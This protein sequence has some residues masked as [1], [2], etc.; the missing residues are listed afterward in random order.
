[1]SASTSHSAFVA[2]STKWD[3][4]KIIGLLYPNFM[5]IPKTPWSLKGFFF[6]TYLWGPKK[7]NLKFFFQELRWRYFSLTFFDS[8][9]KKNLETINLSSVWFGVRCNIGWVTSVYVKCMQ[10]FPLWFC[11]L[12]RLWTILL[13]FV[14]NILIGNDVFEHPFPVCEQPVLKSVSMF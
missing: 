8:T 4:V 14:E 7:K 11:L 2:M 1:M 5:K 9:L 13:V 3:G 10:H 12:F 6:K